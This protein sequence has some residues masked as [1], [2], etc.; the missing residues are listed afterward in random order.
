MTQHSRSTRLREYIAA[1]LPDAHGHQQ[2]AI[3]AFVCGLIA[4]RS[5]CQATLARWYGNFEAAAK[6]LARSPLNTKKS[7][8]IASIPGI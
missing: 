8:W 7:L 5:C 6:R 1:M 2:K 3:L 4:E